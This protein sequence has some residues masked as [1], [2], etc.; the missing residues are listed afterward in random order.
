MT[1]SQEAKE[2]DKAVGEAEIT[3]ARTTATVQAKEG[4]VSRLGQA[5]TDV[6]GDVENSNE[7]LDAILA[8]TEK[9]KGMCTKKPVSF[10]EKMAAMQAEI[11]S[12]KEALEILEAE[13]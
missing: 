8:Y 4:E 6:K 7:E 2:L 12:L 13:A 1:D 5:I 3:K 9:L 11:A 10:E